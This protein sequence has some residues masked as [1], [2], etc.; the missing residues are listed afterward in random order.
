VPE[1][2]RYQPDQERPVE[3]DPLVA[4]KGGGDWRLVS[5]E[6]LDGNRLQGRD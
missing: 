5:E 1:L 2:H 4:L 3:G 6:I